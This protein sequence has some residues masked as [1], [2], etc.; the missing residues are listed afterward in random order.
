MKSVMLK[1]ICTL[2][3][4]GA[5]FLL[6]G[7]KP[8]NE[9]VAVAILGDVAT[10][11]SDL[12]VDYLPTTLGYFAIMNFTLSPE[13]EAAWLAKSFK[14]SDCAVFE[15]LYAGDYI[16]NAWWS[17]IPDGTCYLSTSVLKNDL[18]E[19]NELSLLLSGEEIL[20]YAAGTND[21]SLTQ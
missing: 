4:L 2:L 8:N 3:M 11:A 18:A 12:E 10:Q 15:A 19:Y 13:L 14:E 9:E 6:I 21:T 20:L 16:S 5:V 7:C 17:K 1:R